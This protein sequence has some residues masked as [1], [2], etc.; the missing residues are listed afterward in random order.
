MIIIDAFRMY[1]D[2]ASIISQGKTTII[3]A[4]R[5]YLHGASISHRVRLSL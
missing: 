4:F 1:K 2:G 3:D 5:G